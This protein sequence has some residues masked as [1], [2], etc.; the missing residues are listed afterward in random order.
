MD[1]KRDQNTSPPYDLLTKTIPIVDLSDPNKDVVARAVAK[2]SE[3]WGIFHVVNHGI[4]LELI[5]KL[6]EAGTNF[7]DLSETDK[8]VV[9][10]KD[11]SNDYEGYTKNLKYVEGEVW[12]ENM[13]HRIWPA[14]CIDFTYWPKNPPTYREVIEEYTKEAKKLSETILG[15]LS[16]GLGLQR[17]ALKEG[18][19][20]ENIEYMMRINNYPPNP[21]SNLTLGIPEHTDIIGI[22]IIV[23]NEVLGLQ[24]C[25]DDHWFDVEYIPSAITINI[26]DQ[27]MRLSNGKYKS[28]LHRAI[29]D[30]VHRRMSWPV[31]VDANPDMVIGPLPEIISDD[32]P[33]KFKAI[34]CKDFKYRRL[35]KLPVD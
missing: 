34:T 1:I 15:C 17:E 3:E 24:V 6:K 21:E 10:K 2:A 32:K 12:T 18:L 27:I 26:G 7:F 4:P 13:F 20:G 31:F 25:K 16:E 9:A 8:N 22:A 14:S 30:K 29:V 28:V 11:G 35:F 33:S 23:T 5:C 19:G